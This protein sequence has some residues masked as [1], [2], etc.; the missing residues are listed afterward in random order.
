[1]AEDYAGLVAEAHARL[2]PEKGFPWHT[3]VGFSARFKD[4]NAS[5]MRRGLFLEFRLSRAWHG[6]DREIIIGLFQELLIRVLRAKG[7]RESRNLSLYHHYLQSLH[8]AREEQPLVDP[9]LEESFE[10]V[11]ARHFDGTLEKPRLLFGKPSRSTYGH[12]HYATD[13]L[14]LSALLAGH[15]ELLDYV[16]HHELLHKHL[17]YEH[18][19]GSARYHTGRFRKLESAYPESARLERELRA[20]TAGR[21]VRRRKKPFRL[22]PF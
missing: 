6:V 2:F 21:G 18:K 3:S 8:M 11:N 19:G 12:Y 9:L 14:T 16:M 20:L 17:K 22:W 7:A 4:Y 5:V 13:T 1:M 15:P 10:R